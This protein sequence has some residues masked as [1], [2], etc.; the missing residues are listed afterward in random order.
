MNT[1]TNTNTRNSAPGIDH[2][3]RM[4]AD[5]MPMAAPS[6]TAPPEP[7]TTETPWFDLFAAMIQSAVFPSPVCSRICMFGRPGTGKSGAPWYAFG[8][9]RCERITIH[10]SMP[11][12]DL[13]GSWSL[14]ARGGGTDTVWIDG[15]ATRAM[16]ASHERLSVLVL[17][18]ID[19]RGPD[20][21]TALHQIL[22]DVS[23]ARILLPNGDTVTTGNGWG[24][25]ATMNGSPDDL[26]DALRDRFDVF[27]NCD[28]P[29][30]GVL[31]GMGGA[32]RK[33]VER[34]IAESPAPTWRPAITP[35]RGRAFA[36]FAEVW[37]DECAAAVIFGKAAPDVLT[38][39]GTVTT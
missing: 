8:A 23:M 31:G 28:S 15:V 20:V 5:S 16:R 37:G 35:R 6:P 4:W 2:V 11:P 29:A 26:S 12:E 13:L 30:P 22:D 9:D 19:K 10:N 39:L 14:Q 32:M 25:V 36:R 27:L 21:E 38:M 34:T 7:I 24:A 1:N 17:D 18:E 3:C 33:L